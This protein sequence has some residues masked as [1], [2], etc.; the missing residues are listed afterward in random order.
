MMTEKIQQALN[1]QYN[2]ELYSSYL[3]LSMSAWFE[4]IDLQGFANWMKVQAEEELFHA[5][6]VFRYLIE[7]GVRVIMQPVDAPPCDWTDT[8]SVVEATLEHEQKVTAGINELVYLA[9]DERDN[10][11][12]VYLQWFIHEQVEE[13]SNVG[14]VLGQ[15][16]LAGGNPQAILLLDRELGQRTFTPPTTAE[17]GK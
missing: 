14:T 5:D 4:S 17:G 6:K 16:R 13:E 3:Y 1:D 15:V 2:A 9:R 7:R 10:A 11:S 12:E 8:E